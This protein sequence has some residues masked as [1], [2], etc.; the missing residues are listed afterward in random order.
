MYQVLY[1]EILFPD[2]NL[3]MPQPIHLKFPGMISPGMRNN[4]DDFGGGHLGF[5]AAILNFVEKMKTPNF[6]F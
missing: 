6:V 5:V 3:R 2:D 1:P 4:A